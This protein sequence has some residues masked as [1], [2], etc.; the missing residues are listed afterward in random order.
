LPSHLKLA[1]TFF[2]KVFRLAALLLLL[3]AAFDTIAVDMLGPM[4][5]KQTSAQNDP[6]Q[7]SGTT[8]DDCFCCSTSVVPIQAVVWAPTFTIVP[9]DE[10][11]VTFAVSRA[12]DPLYH[13]PRA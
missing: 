4:W 13:P 12:P 3:S 10:Q 2:P 6:C 11:L 9:T 5:Q 8:Q 7:R 1:M